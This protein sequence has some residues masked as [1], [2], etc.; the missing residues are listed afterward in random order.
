MLDNDDVLPHALEVAH[1]IAVNT[2]PVS[3][4][5]TKRLMWGSFG[6]D[7]TQVD[8]AE[9]ELHKVVMGEADAREGVNAYLERRDAGVVAHR[10]RVLAGRVAR[11]RGRGPVTDAPTTTTTEVLD[12]VDLSGRTALVTGATTGIGKETARALAAAGASVVITART[13]EKGE[14]AVAELVEL[15][16]GADISYE[17]LELASLESVRAF[18]DRFTAEPTT[19]STS[20]SPTPGSC[21]RPT[22]APTT[23]SSS[24]SAPTTWATSCSWA[25]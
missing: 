5:V 3:V 4:A 10:E 17:V 19:G 8:H 18:T 16:P 20:S 21:S 14:T 23:A 24:T 15:V 13:D 6:L 2:A 1:D 22:G 12:G 9:S 7:P 11:A 25:G